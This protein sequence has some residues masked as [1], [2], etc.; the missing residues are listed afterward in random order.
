MR[1]C[2]IRSKEDRQ[3]D[4]STNSASKDWWDDT[5]NRIIKITPYMQTQ[6]YSP[7]I[8]DQEDS[9][10]EIIMELWQDETEEENCEDIADENEYD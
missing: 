1:R 3:L 5:K 4:R 2:T 7:R 6:T 8:T 10:L 9:M